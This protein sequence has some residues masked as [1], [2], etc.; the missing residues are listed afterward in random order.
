MPDGERC[1]GD[2]Q[3]G[4]LRVYESSGRFTLSVTARAGA[5][6]EATGTGGLTGVIEVT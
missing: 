1:P 3:L 2:H 5:C 4:R 6:S